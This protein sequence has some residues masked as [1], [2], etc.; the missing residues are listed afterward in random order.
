MDSS[1][2][3]LILLYSIITNQSRINDKIQ[4]IN[5]IFGELTILLICIVNLF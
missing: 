3:V 1:V 5:D 4:K 2:K